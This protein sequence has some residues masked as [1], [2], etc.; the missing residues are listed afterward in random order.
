MDIQI[1]FNALPAL[2]TETNREM[3]EAVRKSAEA[4][5]EAAKESIRSGS[6]SGRVYKKRGRTHR[7]SGP[8][9]SPAS[10]SKTLENSGEVVV[11]VDGMEAEATFSAPYADDLELGTARTAARPYLTPAASQQEPRF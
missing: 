8:G 4:T 9:E 3:K 6:K 10:D 2:I 5:V 7:A 11:S 1:T